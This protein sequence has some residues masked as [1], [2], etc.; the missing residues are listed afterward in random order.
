MA[1]I[2]SIGDP[3][4][5]SADY[6]PCGALTALSGYDETS[7]IKWQDVADAQD[8]DWFVWRDGPEDIHVDQ[9]IVEDGKII[10]KGG[11]GLDYYPECQP[12]RFAD[13]VK[14]ALAKGRTKEAENAAT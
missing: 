9:V 1:A 11:C 12:C 13:D 14:S 8:G 10:G 4:S 5:W 7:W 2:R 3:F 6:M